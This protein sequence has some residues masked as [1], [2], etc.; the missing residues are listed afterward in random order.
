MFLPL[1]CGFRLKN[2]TTFN[3]N[4]HWAGHDIPDSILRAQVHFVN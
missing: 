1:F 2:S 3:P 4:T